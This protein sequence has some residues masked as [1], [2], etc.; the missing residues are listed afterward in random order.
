MP[1]RPGYEMTAAARH[2]KEANHPDVGLTL[3]PEGR[4]R[5]RPLPGWVEHQRTPGKWRR[6]WDALPLNVRATVVVTVWLFALV[7]G[8]W[9]VKQAEEPSPDPYTGCSGFPVRR[10]C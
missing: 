10:N 8:H 4:P 6:R 5:R 2:A 3:A 7:M 9:F 1:T